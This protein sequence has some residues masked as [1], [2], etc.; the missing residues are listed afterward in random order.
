MSFKDCIRRAM[1]SGDAPKDR[2]RAA[3]ELWQ[4]IADT[5]ERQGYPR[6]TAETLAAS[7]VKKV[8]RANMERDRHTL[9]RQLQVERRNFRLAQTSQKPE[10]LPLRIIEASTRSKNQIDSVVGQMN[11]LTSE[12]HGM[13]GD[14]LNHHG[15]NPAGSVRNRATL[16][17]VVKELHGEAS[18]DAVAAAFAK[19]VAD[20]FERA[21]LLFNAAGGHIGKLD[22]F[23]MPHRHDRER[24]IKAGYEQWAGAVRDRL[25][26]TRIQNNMT[27]RPF[28]TNGKPPPPDV[29]EG[30]LKEIWQGIVTDGWNRRD[31]KW[32]QRMGTALHN[33]NSASRILHFKSADAWMRYND[34][35]GAA[36][37]FA[38][39]TGHLRLMARD[40]AMMRSLGPSQFS[41]LENVYQHALKRVA[42]TPAEA[43]LERNIK[44][45]RIML[46]IVSGDSEVPHVPFWASFFRGVRQTLTAAHLGS[47]FLV[48]G[49]DAVSMALAAKSIGMKPGNLLSR[50]VRLLTSSATRAEARRMG[51]VAD[52]LANAG[53]T[54]DRFLGEAPG[55]G[56]TERLSSFV[57]RASLLTHWTDMNRVAWQMEMA[58]F[59]ADFPTLDSLPPR[60]AD[61]LR[62]RGITPEDW[63]LFGRKEWRFTTADGADFAQPIHWMH[64]AIEGGVERETAERIALTVDGFIHEM[65]EIAVPSLN[66]ETRALMLAGTQPGT[67]G[68]EVLRS[69]M[70]YKSF[71]TSFTINQFRQI[72]AIPTGMGRLKYFA[73]AIAGFTFMGAVSLQLRQIAQGN[74]PQPMDNL[75]FWGRA[76]LQ[77]GGLGIAG[78]LLTASESRIGGGVGNYV[79]GPVAGFVQDLFG[80][81]VWNA[82]QAARGDDTNIGREFV[83]FLKRNVPGTTL[84]QTRAA[85]DR[86]VW[87]QL[88]LLLDPEAEKAMR[89]EVARQRRDYGNE[90]FW[91]PAAPLP[92]TR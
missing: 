52:T 4:R 41:G 83:R 54:M 59:L 44:T 14:F 64:S 16:G 61:T 7:D 78:D 87:D 75:G 2:G 18:G 62:Q 68:G 17:N 37:P 70:S 11:A 23:G 22:D 49:T 34:A 51:Y 86:L 91:A 20:T 72:M 92:F 88:Q 13:V 53:A 12:F 48:S 77:G 60:V 33:R 84:W 89:Q 47:A 90:P 10:E 15:R 50:Q 40:I 31:V 67:P 46:D 82:V 19:A 79:A 76:L 32:G 39:I 5:Y 45:A 8:L 85:L 25:D 24:I 63:A 55:R 29:Q 57:M 74:E 9:M 26:W 43:A 58:G 27:G 73:S 69:F 21:R 42:G 30:F 66:Y 80:L 56:I 81:T 65:Q 3:T 35:F 28:S 38:A 1:D 36:D 6:D 71:V